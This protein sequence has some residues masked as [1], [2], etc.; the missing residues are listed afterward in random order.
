MKTM[1]ILRLYKQKKRTRTQEM[2]KAGQ[3]PS[4]T[5]MTWETLVKE[6]NLFEPHL[7]HVKNWDN[8]IHISQ[9][10]IMKAE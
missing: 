5:L 6:L 1:M 8:C 9:K 3:N 7:R 10:H 2:D 4:C